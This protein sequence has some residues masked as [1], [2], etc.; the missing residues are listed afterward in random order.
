M[1]GFSNPNMAS[2]TKLNA[3]ASDMFAEGT[4]ARDR[5]E[6]VRDTVLLASVLFCVA[7]AQRFT[8]R[9]IR[10]GANA[11]ALVLLLYTLFTLVDLPRV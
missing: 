3:Q 10:I 9:G 5:N 6:Y 2:A 1:P 4:V 7:L 8:V 11:L